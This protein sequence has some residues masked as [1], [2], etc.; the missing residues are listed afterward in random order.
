MSWMKYDKQDEWFP[1]A[2][3]QLHSELVTTLISVID[4][5][6]CH[7]HYSSGPTLYTMMNTVAHIVKS[8]P[9]LRHK[10]LCFFI[11]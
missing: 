9:L 2:H 6:F 5:R 7:Q 1:P 4:C 10:I 11:T 3:T 8:H